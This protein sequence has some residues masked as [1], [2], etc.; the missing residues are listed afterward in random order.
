MSTYSS[1]GTS[2]SMNSASPTL[3]NDAADARA[4]R[5]P[6]LLL[7]VALCGLICCEN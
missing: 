3:Q 1:A 5:L 4:L 2:T 6:S 7:F